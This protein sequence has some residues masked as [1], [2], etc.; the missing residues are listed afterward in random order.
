ATPA[1]PIK[2]SADGT[3]ADD[4]VIPVYT[5]PIPPLPKGIPVGAINAPVL[6]EITPRI[7]SAMRAVLYKGK[8]MGNDPRV[9]SLVG[10]CHTDHAAFFRQFGTGKYDLGQ[11]GNLQEVISYFGVQAG[12]EGPNSFIASQQA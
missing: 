3:G 8:Q 6:P 1:A 11:Y 4:S 9:F 5:L 7:R 10:D 2:P 12:A